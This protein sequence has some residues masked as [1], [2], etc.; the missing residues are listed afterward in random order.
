MDLAMAVRA[1]E[2]TFVEFLTNPFPASCV[3]SAGN[4]EVLL[5]RVTV[6]KLQRLTASIVATLATPTSQI[7][8]RHLP[9]LPAP[10]LDGLN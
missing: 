5:G 6:M 10:L 9:Y 2:D 7:G 1:E 3:S 4:A 8:N